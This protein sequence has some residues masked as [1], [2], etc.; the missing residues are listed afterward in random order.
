MQERDAQAELFAD[1]VGEPLA[2][3][4]AHA[5]A[6]F[7]GDDEH[8]GDGQQGPQRQV[9]EARA[10]RGIGEDA[11]G[12]VID[13]GGDEAR[14]DDGE[15]DSQVIAEPAEEFPHPSLLPQHGDDVVGGDHAGQLAVFVHHGQSQ[16]VVFVEEFGDA[17]L[18]FV[19]GHLD[20]GFG[21][22]FLERACRRQ[23]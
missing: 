17:V 12:I 5:G 19:H 14:A 20:Q 4:G 11:A 22:Q 1:E 21:G 15:E 16:Q 6:H 10:G 2:G 3:D 13:D 23:R 8:H 7:L 18:F 9:A